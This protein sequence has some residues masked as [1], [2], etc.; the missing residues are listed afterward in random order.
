M[1]RYVLPA[2]SALCIGA[3]LRLPKVLGQGGN[4]SSESLKHER[5]SGVSSGRELSV[6]KALAKVSTDGAVPSDAMLERDHR[7]LA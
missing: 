7:T 4:A 3:Y 1:A 5:A 6:K 2:F